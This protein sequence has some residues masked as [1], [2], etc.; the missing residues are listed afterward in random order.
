MEEATGYEARTL[1]RLL[2]VNGNIDREDGGHFFEKDEDNPIEADVVIVDEMSMVDIHL[3]CALLRALMPGTKLILV[4]DSYQLASVGP[5][6]V[7]RDLIK[8]D[9]LPT[10]RLK[11]IYRQDENG[12][13]IGYAHMIK[14]GEL[15]DFSKKYRDFFLLE[16]DRPEVILDY[17]E[18]LIKDNV[19]REFKIKPMDIQ[20]LTPM[21]KG[22][23]GTV[24][25][26]RE[27]Q[28]RMNP[29]S[30]TKKE[31]ICGDDIFREGDKV[32]Q[33]KNNY[34]LEWEIPGMYNIPTD[35]GTGVYNGDVGTVKEINGFT[36]ELT[37]EFDD[38]RNIIYPYDNLEELELAYAVTI[39]KSQGSEYPVVIMPVLSGPDV[40]LTRNLLYTGVTRAKE[41]VIMLGSSR[42]VS[43]MILNDTVRERYTSLD[44]CVIERMVPGD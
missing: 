5:G 26:N 33:I 38:G 23:L 22:V 18:K 2:E 40:L 24:E 28:R 27:L 8:S 7:F 25:L 20:V 16:K 42:T 3:F 4:G 17:M 21:K 31:M 12:H 35:K 36:R 15:I 44:R 9:C 37:V 30:K 29:P 43:S 32:M 41:C 14:N 34:D 19:P 11:H 13:I 10:A 39:H 6:Q 1:H